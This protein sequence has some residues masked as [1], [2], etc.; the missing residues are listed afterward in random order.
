MY[1]RVDILKA[2][3]KRDLVIKPF[4]KKNLGWVEY[5]LHL[6]N[7]VA[8]A[9]K[10]VVDIEKVKNFER[11]YQKNKIKDSF[12]IRPGQLVLARTYEKISISKKL[13]AFID[14]RSTL[15]RLGL[16]VVQH[17][18]WVGGGHGFPEPR[19]IVLEMVNAGPFN[20]VLRP[21]MEIAKLIL[22]EFDTPSDIGYDTYGKYGRRKYKDELL[23]LKG[24]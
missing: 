17:A 2:I 21:R 22:F 1:S 12:K 5:Q 16:G 14:G 3:K 11:F 23:P 9:K 7:E 10:G 20:I 13:A 19:K 8:I 6:D 24:E 4:N 15:A 18:Y